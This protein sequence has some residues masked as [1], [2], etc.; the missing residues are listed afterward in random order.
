LGATGTAIL[1]V[2]VKKKA[3]IEPLVGIMRRNHPAARYNFPNTA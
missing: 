2:A 1:E 3:L